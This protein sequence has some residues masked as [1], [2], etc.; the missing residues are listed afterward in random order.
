M[1]REDPTADL[2]LIA[3]LKVRRPDT[4]LEPGETVEGV[5]D[6]L[7]TLLAS[8]HE[9]GTGTPPP[10]LLDGPPPRRPALRLVWRAS[11]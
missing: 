4:Y 9:A 3:V 10:R 5:L 7:R 6:G 8:E 1:D 2:C 11:L